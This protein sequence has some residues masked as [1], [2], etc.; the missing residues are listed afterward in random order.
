MKR[1][2]TCKR[3][4][5]EDSL[6]YCLDD[7]TPLTAE[8]SPQPDPE[9]TIVTPPAGESRVSRELPPTQYAQL[10]GKATVSASGVEIPSMPSYSP[11]PPK[12]RV[13]PWVVAGLVGLFLIGIVIA[14]VIAI[15]MMMKNSSN[16]NRIANSPVSSPEVS[17]P[18]SDDL[19]SDSAPTDEDTVLAQLTEIEKQWTEANVKGDKVAIER[20]LADEYSGGEPPHTKREYIRDLTHDPAVNS[21][22]LQDLRVRL[23]GNKAR[24]SGYLRQETTR[25]TEVYSFTDGFIWRDGRWQAVASRAARVK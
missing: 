21:W 19:P 2:P 14:A 18:K 8:S 22:E 25:G 3:A 4:F 15:P 9:E 12:P 5:E 13:W 23:E 16:E 11:S 17:N 24:L 6:T 7:G 10:P 1:C 20:I